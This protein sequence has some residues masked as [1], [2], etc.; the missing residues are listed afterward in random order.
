MKQRT[1]SDIWQNLF[2]FPEAEPEAIPALLQSLNAGPAHTFPPVTHILSHRKLSIFFTHCILP[3]KDIAME[4]AWFT[5]EEA[6]KLPK[7]KVI[8]DLLSR[9][10]H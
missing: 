3:D 9:M 1:G 8:V 6:D 7:P 2:D 10:N 5:P 4:G